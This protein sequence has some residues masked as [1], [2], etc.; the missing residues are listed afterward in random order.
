VVVVFI[1]GTR[2]VQPDDGN[3]DCVSDVRHCL[4]E[5]R[6]HPCIINELVACQNPVRL[7]DAKDWTF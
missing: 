7:R 1:G 6:K 5:P 2:G 3:V 4:Q